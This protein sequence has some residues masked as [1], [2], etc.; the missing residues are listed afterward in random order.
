MQL[1]W[2]HLPEPNRELLA[3]WEC[4]LEFRGKGFW[5]IEQARNRGDVGNALQCSVH[6][7][8][9]EGVL[10]ELGL[11]EEQLAQLFNVS[12]VRATAVAGVSLQ[13]EG[14]FEVN[15]IKASEHHKCPRCWL[16][17]SQSEGTLCQRCSNIAA[18]A[19]LQDLP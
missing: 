18:A 7:T 13:D 19:A 2:P 12:E 9:P 11:D 16:H 15:E 3:K 6:C 8:L 17:V 1:R 4:L 10:T 5:E 14:G